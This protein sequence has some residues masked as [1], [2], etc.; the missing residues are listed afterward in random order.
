MK[1]TTLVILMALTAGPALAQSGWAQPV[2]GCSSLPCPIGPD[3]SGPTQGAGPTAHERLQAWKRQEQAREEQAQRE[4]QA[5]GR[6]NGPPA[7]FFQR[8]ATVF[9]VLQR[10]DSPRILP[11]KLA[12]L[13][14]L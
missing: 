12:V 10:S 3:N 9:R 2:T 5:R 8:A 11:T 13:P 4:E 7:S 6:G 1:T 14:R